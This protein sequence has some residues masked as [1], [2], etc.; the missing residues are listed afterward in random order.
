MVSRLRE[1]MRAGRTPQ[2]AATI[3]LRRAGPTIGA[4]GVILAG[5]FAA[6]MLAN[7]EMLSSIGFAVGFGIFLTAFVMAMFLTPSLTVLLGRRAWW[8]G[9]GTTPGEPGPVV[10]A[11][12]EQVEV[13]R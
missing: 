11:D 9:H 10:P 6:L 8:P 2:E 3:A 4:A 1:E 7:N 5:S 12:A 13:T